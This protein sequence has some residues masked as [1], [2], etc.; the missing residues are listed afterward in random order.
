MAQKKTLQNTS[1]EQ[2]LAELEGCVIAIEEIA[3]PEIK[4][5]LEKIRG[6]CQA[7]YKGFDELQRRHSQQTKKVKVVGRSKGG[8]S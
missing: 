7:A 6:N 4:Q 5:V 8:E 2:L 3:L 1:I